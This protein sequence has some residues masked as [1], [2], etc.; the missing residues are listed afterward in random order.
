MRSLFSKTEASR[1][2]F[3]L[4]RGDNNQFVMLTFYFAESSIAEV[5]LEAV[6]SYFNRETHDFV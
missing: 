6:V 2:K 1:K 5:A 4:V 3:R